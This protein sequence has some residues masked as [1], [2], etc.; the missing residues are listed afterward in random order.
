MT[1]L[2]N[3]NFATTTCLFI[4][5]LF[6][7]KNLN[8]AMQVHILIFQQWKRIIPKLFIAQFD[9]YSEH[10]LLK[11]LNVYCQVCSNLRV[12]GKQFWSK[13]LPIPHII[14][15]SRGGHGSPK[16]L[17]YLVILCFERWYPKQETVASLIKILAP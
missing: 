12:I 15:V 14:G 4:V 6:L 5:I 16:F 11:C 10:N 17:E 7:R 1:S 9:F 3:E 2:G 13:Y 8:M